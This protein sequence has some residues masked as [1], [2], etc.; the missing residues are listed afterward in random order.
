M[1]I[2]SGIS[3]APTTE[4]NSSLKDIEYKT[5]EEH[6]T[7]DR[8]DFMKL[9]VT[10]LQYQDPMN[11]M[12]SAEMASQVAQFNMVDLLYKNNSALE[13]MAK[14]ENT[15]ASVSAVSLL[16][17]K[18]EYQGDKLL[19]SDSGPEPFYIQA[20]DETPITSCKVTIFNKNGETV[21][22]ID[23]GA[24]DPGEK[25]ALEWDGKDTNGEEVP[26]GVYNVRVE[27]TDLNNEEIEL[28]TITTGLV[29]GIEQTDKGLPMIIIKDGPTIEMK[30]I[31]KVG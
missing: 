4:Q 15:A 17:H 12:E 18:V 8:E 22:E 26:E 28:T 1:N 20:P 5:K 21:K 14:A 10:Q 30:D 31:S 2:N 11:P 16:D 29:A 6:A 13:E 9:F 3:P 23:L 27:A 7:L 19:V 25:R 24:L